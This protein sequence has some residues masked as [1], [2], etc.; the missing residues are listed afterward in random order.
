[1]LLEFEHLTFKQQAML[2]TL[3]DELLLMV[4]G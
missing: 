1:M 4:R 3:A 2:L